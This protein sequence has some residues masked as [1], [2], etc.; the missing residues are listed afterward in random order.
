M[1]EKLLNEFK[2]WFAWTTHVREVREKNFLLKVLSIK[3]LSKS[4]LNSWKSLI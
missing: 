3:K 2:E 1:D 4:S